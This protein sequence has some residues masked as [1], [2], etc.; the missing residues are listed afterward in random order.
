MFLKFQEGYQEKAN[1]PPLNH[2]LNLTHYLTM[3]QAA[4]KNSRLNHYT[5]DC[6]EH[7]SKSYLDSFVWKLFRKTRRPDFKSG[8]TLPLPLTSKFYSKKAVGYKETK[9][10]HP[11]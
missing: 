3:P 11:S 9:I 5:V 7:V 10:T 8:I 6:L 4:G 2:P 1:C